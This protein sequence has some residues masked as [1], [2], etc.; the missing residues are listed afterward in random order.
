MKMGDRASFLAGSATALTLL[1]NR[2]AS[3]QSLPAITILNIPVDT[4]GTAYYAVDKGFFT[5]A[6]LNA[7]ISS[8]TN[9]AQIVTALVA[10]QADF[11][12]SPTTSVVQARERG[13][14]LD[15]VAPAGLY[16][17]TVP[18]H[19]VL[20]RADSPARTL[21]DLVG[22]TVAVIGLQNIGAVALN[23]TL[24]R[25]GIA[26]SSVNIVEM[27]AGTML[28]ALEAGKIDAANLDEP[29]LGQALAK[30]MRNVVDTYRTI[31]PRWLQGAYVCTESYAKANP[32]LVRRFADAIAQAAA[33]ANQ[34]SNA[35]EA[36]KILDKYTNTTTPPERPHIVYAERL[37]S[38]D[39]QPL[40]DVSAKYGLLKSAV[41][42]KDLFAPGIGN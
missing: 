32:D 1:R 34:K 20:V 25:D 14:R 21:R 3:A 42:A 17:T 6:G 40:I 16:T 35:A 2:P 23:A 36:W 22:K 5:R 26:V 19:G 37:I 10:S 31:A 24:E 27:P 4:A 30:G 12:V 8:L 38:A 11:G 39:V 9:G 7:S 13:I 28:V 15:M 41:P 33:W 18:S 29:F